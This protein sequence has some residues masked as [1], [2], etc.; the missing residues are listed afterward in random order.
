M[1]DDPGALNLAEVRAT[2]HKMLEEL[3]P[4]AGDA[5]REMAG[6]K[7]EGLPSRMALINSVMDALPDDM[8]EL[9]LSQYM[10][11]VFV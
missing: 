7:E 11:E 10:N 1:R 2:V 8:A 9:M 5:L 3:G 4:Q 6:I